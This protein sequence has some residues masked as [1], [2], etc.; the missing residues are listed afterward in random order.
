M[1]V[2]APALFTLVRCYLVS[3][4]F[5]TTWHTVFILAVRDHRTNE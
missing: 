4:S 1:T 5:F 3:F 2:G